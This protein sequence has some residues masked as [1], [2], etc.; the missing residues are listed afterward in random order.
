MSNYL[1]RQNMNGAHRYMGPISNSFGYIL[2]PENFTYDRVEPP[3]PPGDHV[4][5]RRTAEPGEVYFSDEDWPVKP[6]TMSM[7]ERNVPVFGRPLLRL[8][9][10]DFSTDFPHTWIPFEDMYAAVQPDL[11]PRPLGYGSPLTTQHEGERAMDVALPSPWGTEETMTHDA[12]GFGSLLS[13]ANGLGV[14]G[15]AW[16]ISAASSG[17]KEEADKAEAEGKSADTVNS[18]VNF[19]SNIAALYLQHQQF[20]DLKKQQERAGATA[21]EVERLKV[22]QQQ[23]ALQAAQARAPQS[24]IDDMRPKEEPGISPLVIGAAAVGATI[25]ATQ[26]L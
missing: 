11:P 20:K 17:V 4:T 13:A 18:I 12:S 6:L 1:S 7:D 9:I 15:A 5:K 26:V 8:P 23:L 21:L 3:I 2:Y 10:R 25:L 16:D 24:V 14:W 19:G 22:Q